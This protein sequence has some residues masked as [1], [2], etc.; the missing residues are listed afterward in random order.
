MITCFVNEGALEYHIRS[1]YTTGLYVCHIIMYG[2]TAGQELES[3]VHRISYLHASFHIISYVSI[4]TDYIRR[5][6][7]A[8]F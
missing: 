7:L 5:A 4:V 3:I 2:G 6:L 1:L 8:I